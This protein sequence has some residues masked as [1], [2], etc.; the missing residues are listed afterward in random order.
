MENEVYVASDCCGVHMTMECA[1]LGICPRCGEHCEAV[2][3]I[4][5]IPQ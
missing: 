5:P 3:E 1:E 2:V 4:V